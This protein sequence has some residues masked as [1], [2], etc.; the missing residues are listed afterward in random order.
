MPYTPT[1]LDLLDP[2]GIAPLIQRWLCAQ[3]A[4]DF[5]ESATSRTGERHA[6]SASVSVT[7]WISRTW[8]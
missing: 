5:V 1:R 3:P 8:L 2:F 4:V 7:S 6:E